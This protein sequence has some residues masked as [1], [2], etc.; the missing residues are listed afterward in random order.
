[1]TDIVLLEGGTGQELLN[2]SANKSPR[3]WSAE[4]LLA[5]PELVQQVHAD[6]IAAG[7]RV[8]TINAYSA[9]FTRMAILLEEDLV[10]ELQRIACDLALRARDAAGVAGVAIAGC[11]P[12]L[13][14]TYRPDR[15]R[16]FATN[17][18]EY[19]R[20]AELQAPHVDF[21]RCETLSSA[22]EGRAAAQAACETGK[23][24]W[25][26]WTLADDGGGLRSG[27]SIAEAHAALD[28][29]PVSAVLANC[30]P[31]EAITA[32]IPA[33]AATGLPAGGY[34]NGF[35]PVPAT[36]VP[37]RTLEQITLREDLSPEA[38]AAIALEWIDRG[39][40]IVGGCCATG[41]AHIKR[42]REAILQ[43]G[44]GIG[45]IG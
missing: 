15:V 7:A 9:T 37:G 33:L 3:R 1:M 19:R 2:R 17:L 14:G 28:G 36:F 20:L 4:Y 39:A 40:R 34:A 44:F 16:P 27:E 10:P 25:V 6:Y 29:L 41:P 30:S 13:N 18:A 43:R 22:E 45:G 31:P 21:F 38:Y 35:M 11:L 26:A 23:P 24:V 8:I 12:P 42:L 32:A 5:E